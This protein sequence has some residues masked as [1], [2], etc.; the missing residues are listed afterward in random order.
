VNLSVR[1]QCPNWFDVDRVQVF[2]NGRP[3]AQLNFTRAN[4]AAAFSSK[5]VRFERTIA[6]E[7]AG[8]TQVVVATIGEHSQLGHV[9]GPEHEK[10]PPVAVANPIYVDVDGGGF[11]ANRDT[12][13]VPLPVKSATAK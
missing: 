10:L 1:V 6:L 7:L 8:D 12:L 13:G 2:V 9:V 4:D 11:T 3:D 5:T